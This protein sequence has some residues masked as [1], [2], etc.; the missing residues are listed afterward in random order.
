[1]NLELLIA[2]RLLKGGN[3]GSVSVP[4]VRIAQA[5]IVLGVCV[6]LLSICITG[7]FKKEITDKLTGFV[8]HV[9]IGSYGGNS[10]YADGHIRVSDTLLANITGFKAVR[11]ASVYVSKPA[12]LKTGREIHGALLHGVSAAYRGDF[13]KKE[14]REG[15]FPDFT[16]EQASDQILLSASVARLLNLRAGD[17]LQAHFV[18]DPPRVRVFTVSGI[19]DTGFR[20]YDDVFVLCDIRHLQRLNGWAP[21][22]V[23]GLSVTLWDIN[24]LSEAAEEI[25]AQLGWQEGGDFYRINTLYGTAPEIFDWLNLLNM[26]VWIILILVILVAGM[27]MVSGLLILILDKTALIGILKALGYRNIRLRKLFLYVTAGLVGKGMLWGNVA[28]LLLAGLQYFFRLIPLDPES[29]YMD[30]VPVSFDWPAIIGLNAGV[31]FVSILMLI[32]PTVL[33]SGIQPVK[34]I[35]F[36]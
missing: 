31:W 25:E 20:E 34:A 30:T 14:L 21:E 28:A 22:E 24:R 15:H 29:Y 17:K 11:E 10:A 3:K 9:D 18:Q 26:N 5:G 32:V 27:N 23:S 6:M 35:R 33:I 8:S 1:M 13:F 16:T 19:Y 12:I 4:I 36:E 7:G 2:R